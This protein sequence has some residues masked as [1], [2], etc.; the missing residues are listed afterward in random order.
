MTALATIPVM[1]LSAT[2][3]ARLLGGALEGG[4]A[5]VVPLAGITTDSRDVIPGG[6]FVAVRG[7]AAD[8]HAFVADA[9]ARGAAVAVVAR[10]WQPANGAAPPLLLRVADPAAAL[11]LACRRRLEELG[12]EV[13]GITGSVGK[14]TTKDLCALAVADR[15]VARTPGNLNTWTG[16]PLTVLRLDSPVERFVV[17]LA[18]S[19]PGEIADLCSFV[20]P[21]I[22]VLLNV[23]YAHV[24]LLGSIAAI[25]DA[26][27]ELLDA[28]PADGAACLNADDAEVV[29]VAGR[30]R[31][32]L[33]WFGLHDR[34]AA[35]RAVDIEPDRMNGVRFTLQTPAGRAPVRLRVPGEHAVLDACAAAAVAWVLDV[36]IADAA[37]RLS[38][39][40]PAEHRGAVRIGPGGCIVYDDCYNSSPTSLAAALRVLAASGAATRVAVLG[41][42]LEL[43]DLTE[44]A[45]VEAGRQAAAAATHLVAVGDHAATMV[46]A[47]IAAGMPPAHATIADGADAAAQQ[48]LPRCGDGT[49]VLVKASHSLALERVVELLGAP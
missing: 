44:P 33:V 19:A 47:A 4:A 46:E 6:A 7:T 43:G 42:M 1:R 18:M 34:G 17:E 15:P 29:R 20:Q 22:G 16:V 36:S 25:A 35:I 32:P 11:R 37:E 21:R 26:K 3:L 48:V 23:G 30:S 10:G 49:V 28:L 13:I 2:D 24:G 9:A 31:A 40:E 39:F 38:T 27:A 12:C 45:H 5:T 14:T 8:G 41:D